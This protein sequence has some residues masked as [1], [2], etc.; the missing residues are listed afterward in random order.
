[1]CGLL[2]LLLKTTVKTENNSPKTQFHENWRNG[3][4]IKYFQRV[5]ETK[6]GGPSFPA[7]G[8]Q[9]IL[10]PVLK[11]LL[12]YARNPAGFWEE[13][14]ELFWK[15]SSGSRGESLMW[16]IY[17]GTTNIHFLFLIKSLFFFLNKNICS[18]KA[19]WS[20]SLCVLKLLMNRK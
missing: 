14:R 7:A 15:I 16:R 1:M 13:D 5:P 6:N 2:T 18:A 11:S 12:L 9:K 19:V 8:T 4:C 3:L 10:K 20:F 17:A